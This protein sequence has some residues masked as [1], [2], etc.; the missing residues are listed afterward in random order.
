MRKNKCADNTGGGKKKKKKIWHVVHFSRVRV[1]TINMSTIYIRTYKVSDTRYCV[2]TGR[3]LVCSSITSTRYIIRSSASPVTRSSCFS[4]DRSG[5]SFWLPVLVCT[6]YSHVVHQYL[7]AYTTVFDFRSLLYEYA[8]THSYS[9]YIIP[10]DVTSTLYA[11]NR[12]NE[13]CRTYCCTR[14]LWQS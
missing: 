1:R 2:I 11:N 3:L 13:H 10:T 5:R 12:Y 9:H 14:S 6:T 8:R 7:T 4:T